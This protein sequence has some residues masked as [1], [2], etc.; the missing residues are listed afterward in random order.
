M[1]SLL[2]RVYKPETEFILYGRE[3]QL[4]G[5]FGEREKTVKLYIQFNP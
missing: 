2:N 5:Y 3:Y 4:P 1:A